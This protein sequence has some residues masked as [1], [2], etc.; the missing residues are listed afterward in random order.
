[1]ELA[2]IEFYQAAFRHATVS[3]AFEAGS[4]VVAELPSTGPE[5][6]GEVA[7]FETGAAS[8]GI[9]T[10][11]IELLPDD[12]VAVHQRALAAG[13]LLKRSITEHEYECDRTL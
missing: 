8:S 1:M 9:P 3:P 13:R 2:A 4:D 6:F 10:V 5:F 12:P 7:G 11:R